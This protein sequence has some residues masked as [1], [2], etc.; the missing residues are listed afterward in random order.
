MEILFPRLKLQNFFG[1]A[2]PPRPPTVF[3]ENR[4]CSPIPHFAQILPNMQHFPNHSGPIPELKKTALAD[5]F[6]F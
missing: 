1:V 6:Y 3:G 2:T 5:L 4:T